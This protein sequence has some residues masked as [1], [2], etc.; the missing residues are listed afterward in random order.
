MRSALRRE[1]RVA[2]LCAASIRA[3]AGDPYLHLRGSRLFRGTHLLPPPAAHLRSAG[4]G[5]DLNSQRGAADG[6]ALR[7]LKTDLNLHEALAPAD[8]LGRSLFDL[9][10]QYRVESLAPEGLIGVRTNLEH[11]HMCWTRQF[12]SGGLT[13]SEYGLLIFTAAQVCRARILLEPMDEQVQDIVE[14]TRNALAPRIGNA[15]RRLRRLRDNQAKYAEAATEVASVVSSMASLLDPSGK[16]AAADDDPCDDTRQRVAFWLGAQESEEETVP[17]AA[18]G[19]SRALDEAQGLYRVFTVAYDEEAHSES[20]VR[21]DL[22]RE[23]RM[24]LDQSAAKQ[25]V[26]PTR[27]ARELQ[28]LL[29][30]PHRD[31]WDPGQEEGRIDGR[32]LAQLVA[33]PKERRLFRIERT[34]RA[35]DCLVTFLLDCSGSMKGYSPRVALLVDTFSRALEQGGISSEVLGFTTRAWNGGRARRDWL[36]E[37]SASHPGRLTEVSHI[38]FKDAS[39]TWRRA[40]RALAALLKPDLYREGVDGEAVEWACSRMRCRAESRRILVAISDGSPMDASTATANDPH[41]LDVHLQDVV[42]RQSSVGDIEICAVGVGLDLSA[43]YPRNK[44]LDLSG[45]LNYAVFR[46]VSSLIAGGKCKQ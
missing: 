29:A 37:G 46:E 31:G 17:V 1:Q 38:V 19:P 42:A 26:N 45:P 39:S 35:A 43:Y 33:S 8:A 27:L 22:L 44:V 23:L 41:Y 14:A 7:A 40:K 25:G 5:D 20:L 18:V 11:R 6:L 30:D 12:L 24:Q 2:E 15:L 13:D 10:E 36:R 9:L 21:G 3:L 16:E 34:E 32:R 28:L 4:D